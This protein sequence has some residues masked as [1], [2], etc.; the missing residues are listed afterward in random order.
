MT[1]IDENTPNDAKA[2]EAEATSPHCGA[3][4]SSGA[5]RTAHP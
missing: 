4:K 1:H 5:N 2:G 3:M